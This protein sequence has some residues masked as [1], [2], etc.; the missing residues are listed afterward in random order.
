MSNPP[1]LVDNMSNPPPLVDN[2]SNPPHLIDNLPNPPPLIDNMP[3]PPPLIGCFGLSPLFEDHVSLSLS[4]VSSQTQG[5]A[6]ANNNTLHLPSAT[7][8]DTP[9]CLNPHHLK[10]REGNDPQVASLP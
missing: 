6:K 1:H 5:L 10:V 4:V 2:L 8:A 9:V 3:N 7:H